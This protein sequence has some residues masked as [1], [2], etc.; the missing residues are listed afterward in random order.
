MKPDAAAPEYN[1]R[2][3]QIG[4]FYAESGYTVRAQLGLARVGSEEREMPTSWQGV[5][6]VPATGINV[7][8]GA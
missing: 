4:K 6:F 8:R 7:E 3:T 5:A 2:Q 1:T